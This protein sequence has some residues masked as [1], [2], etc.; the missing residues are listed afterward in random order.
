MFDRGRH[1]FALVRAAE[2]LEADQGDLGRPVLFAKIFRFTLCPNHRYIPRH[3]VPLRGALA[4]VT[5]V[6]AGCGGRGGAFD[7][8]R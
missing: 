2:F 5:N 1:Y 7:E 8:R 3:P 4:I 6:G